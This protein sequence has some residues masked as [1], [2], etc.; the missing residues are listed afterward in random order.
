MLRCHE[1]RICALPLIWSSIVEC[2][3]SVLKIGS[4]H[5]EYVPTYYFECACRYAQSCHL[6][7]F[8]A[9]NS[10]YTLEGLKAVSRG[11]ELGSMSRIDPEVALPGPHRLAHTAGPERP[12]RLA[13]G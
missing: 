7:D 3:R 4:R 1:V 10:I 2:T 11:D 6:H 13:T 12:R 9:P 8:R 5:C